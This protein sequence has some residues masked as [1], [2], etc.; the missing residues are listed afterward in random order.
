MQSLHKAARRYLGVPFKHRGRKPWALDCAGLGVLAYADC[1]VKLPDFRLYGM[2]PHRDALIARISGALG[3]PI[4]FAPIRRSILRVDDVISMRYEK[5]PHHVAI[6]GEYVLG[7]L[8]LIHAD[9]MAGKVIEHRLADEHIT[10]ITHV[11]RRP[12]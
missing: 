9:G 5:E 7:G 3:E 2:E 11:F 6:V 10:M 4:A 1:G 12:V 8:S